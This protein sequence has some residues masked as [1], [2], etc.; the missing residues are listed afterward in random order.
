MCNR[1]QYWKNFRIDK[2]QNNIWRHWTFLELPFS[3]R[4]ATITR[5]ENWNNVGETRTGNENTE[6]E[7]F[8]DFL[9]YTICRWILVAN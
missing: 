8:D 3:T 2:L 1:Y 4:I 9:L 6:V 7:W 5:L